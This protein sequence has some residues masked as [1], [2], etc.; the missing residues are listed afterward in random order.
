MSVLKLTNISKSF[1]EKEAVKNISLEV[2]ENQVFG[3]LGPNGAGK[4]TTI[5]MILGLLK[6]S[7]GSIEILGN[8]VEFG[9]TSYLKEVG[10]VNDVPEFYGWMNAYDYLKLVLRMYGLKELSRIDEVLDFVGLDNTKVKIKQYSRGMKQRLGIAQALIHDPKLIILDEPTSALDPI[11]RKEIL[12]IIKNLSEKKTI[13]YSTHLLDDVERVCDSI[14]IIDRGELLISGRMEEIKDKFIQDMY[15]IQFDCEIDIKKLE[16]LKTVS[17]VTFEKSFKVSADIG[18][19]K[20]LIDL[21]KQEN[22][23]LSL[24]RSV[25]MKLEDIFMKVVNENA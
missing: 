12:E 16:A 1:G 20:E 14:A 11:G 3:I 24:F 13:F 8:K 7:E 2:S 19:N 23:G 9:K 10:Y 17:E 18:F 21:C 15:E 6:V 5:N 4:S 22:Y 25:D